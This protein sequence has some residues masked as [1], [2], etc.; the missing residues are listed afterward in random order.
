MSLPMTRGVTYPLLFF[1][2]SPSWG[3]CVSQ[4]L[5]DKCDKSLPYVQRRQYMYTPMPLVDLFLSIFVCLYFQIISARLYKCLFLDQKPR[6]GFAS[7][8]ACKKDLQFQKPQYFQR[9]HCFLR[10][11]TSQKNCLLLFNH[12]IRSDQM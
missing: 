12:F 11:G 10:Q 8:N 3:N 7:F 2:F 5:L 6:A 4:T 1:P 9:W